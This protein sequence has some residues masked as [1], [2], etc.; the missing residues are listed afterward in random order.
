MIISSRSCVLFTEK[1]MPLH[2]I[3]VLGEWPS[4][5]RRCKYNCNL[6]E[7]EMGRFPFQTPLGARPGLGT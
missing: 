3:Y 1:L 5:L 4:G 2:K 7:F 6:V